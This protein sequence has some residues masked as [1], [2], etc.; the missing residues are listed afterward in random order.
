M[1]RKLSENAK[2][3]IEN[4]VV[5]QKKERMAPISWWTKIDVGEDVIDVCVTYI[6]HNRPDSNTRPVEHE[7]KYQFNKADMIK[8]IP[9]KVIENPF[10]LVNFVRKLDDQYWDVRKEITELLCDDFAEIGFKKVDSIYKTLLD[11]FA[12][13]PKYQMKMNVLIRMEVILKLLKRP[14]TFRGDDLREAM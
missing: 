1:A 2:A 5:S 3:S 10:V 14:K 4:Q 12:N 8:M 11:M 6:A 9:D 13:D 7:L